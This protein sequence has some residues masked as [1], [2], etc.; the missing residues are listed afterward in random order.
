MFLV[1]FQITAFLCFLI[2]TITVDKSHDPKQIIND[3]C[4]ASL[5]TD[6]SVNTK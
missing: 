4:V 5:F 2:N 3:A 6:L 1:L